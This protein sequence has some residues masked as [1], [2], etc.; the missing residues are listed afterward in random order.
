[1]TDKEIVKKIDG[2]VRDA[3]LNDDVEIKLTFN[4]DA[5]GT[6][7]KRLTLV[8]LMNMGA[9]DHMKSLQKMISGEA[10][11]NTFELVNGSAITFL[12][13]QP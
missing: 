2:I 9:I 11:P 8:A 1:M 12:L 10:A 3:L 7:W 4:T 5:E 6:L 13:E